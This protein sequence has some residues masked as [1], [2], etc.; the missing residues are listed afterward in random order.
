MASL[1]DTLQA[2][3]YRA[4]IVPRSD[5]ARTWFKRAVKELGT[6]NRNQIMKDPI[7][8]VRSKPMIG[9][10][11]MY[12]YDPKLKQTLPYYDTFPLTVMVQPAKG[13]FH[14]LNLH[15]HSPVVRAEFLDELMQLGPNQ[16]KDTSRIVKLRYSLLKKAAKFKEFQPCF[17]H[18]LIDHVKS[19]IM[20][21][22]MTE[23][24]I[25]VFLPVDNFKKVSRDTVWR[26]SRKSMYGK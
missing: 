2:G 6:V 8:D 14:G 23:W 7:L 26:Y 25:A 17:K 21:V 12:V 3:A 4:N 19:K 10:M 1:F 16:L 24:E 15:Y 11:C 5:K 9:D 20:R 13:G 22:P 18:Y